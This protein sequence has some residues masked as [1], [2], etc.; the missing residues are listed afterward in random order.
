MEWATDLLRKFQDKETDAHEKDYP[1]VEAATYADDIKYHGGAFQS[2]WHFDALGF[3]G[4]NS[5]ASDFKFATGGYN[6]S[7]A[8]PS[9]FGWLKGEDMTDNY[10]ISQILNHTDNQ[11][12]GYS[13]GLRLFIHF[14]GDIHQ[15]LHCT[16]NYTKDHPKGD[17]GGNLFDLKYHYGADNFHA[18]WDEAMY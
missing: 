1:F 2:K 13:M 10:Y 7:T 3:V 6:I 18:V 4:D 12:E 17:M 14:M 16:S 15:P 11:V 5:S 9:L 8:L